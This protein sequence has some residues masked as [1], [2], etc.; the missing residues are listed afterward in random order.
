MAREAVKWVVGWFSECEI[1]ADWV[2][3]ATDWSPLFIHPF[4][5]FGAFSFDFAEADK[6]KEKMMSEKLQREKLAGEKDVA[7]KNYE[8]E[9]AAY[10]LVISPYEREIYVITMIKIK[11]NEHC[12]RLARGE[13]STFG[14]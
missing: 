1:I 2:S 9:S 14:Q 10:K 7:S 5:S 8:S 13:A 3:S 11:I 12:D 4:L 6:A